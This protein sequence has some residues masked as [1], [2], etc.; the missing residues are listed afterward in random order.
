ME[1]NTILLFSMDKVPKI[2]QECSPKC[3]PIPK[4]SKT[5]DT[6]TDIS[7]EISADTDTNNSFHNCRTITEPPTYVLHELTVKLYIKDEIK[8]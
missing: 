1:Y 2:G 3:R 5:A 4:D 8:K 7:A 6:E